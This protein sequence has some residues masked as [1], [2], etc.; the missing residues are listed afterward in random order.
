MTVPTRESILEAMAEYREIGDSA[1]YSKYNRKR[2]SRTHFLRH[3]GV[4]YPIKA[5]WAAAHIP[6]LNRSGQKPNTIE[7]QLRLIGFSDF[8]GAMNAEDAAAPPPVEMFWEGERVVREVV[9]IMRDKALVKLARL[10]KG[11]K[12]EVC[13]EDYAEKYGD[14]GKRCIE[15]HHLAPLK[16]RDGEGVTTLDQIAALCC[17]CHRMIHYT[18][19]PMTIRKLSSMLRF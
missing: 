18:S 7:A 8:V 16:D 17:N 1:F 14:I 10:K 15:Y 13:G 9:L 19:P 2:R 12:C 4:V 3:E 6:A 11:F 5:L